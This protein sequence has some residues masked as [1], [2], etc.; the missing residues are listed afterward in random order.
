M[1]RFASLLVVMVI[2][3]ALNGQQ[4]A[5]DLIL[6]NGKIITVDERFT[7]AQAVA[8]RGD[9]FVAIGTNQ[10]IARLAGPNTRR[11]DLRGKAVIPGLIDNHMH[12][13]R[14]GATWQSEVRWDGIG[15]RK[16]ALD[17]LRARAKAV[18][19]G[20][21]IYS[22]G[23]WT[24]DQF[25][26]DSRPFTRN[27]LDDAAPN[28]PVLL[29]ASYYETYLNSRALQAL[30]IDEKSP[31]E[32]WLVRDAAGKPTGRILEAGIRGLAARLPEPAPSEIEASS[33]AMI[34]DLNRA[35][36]T[37]FG[38][39]GCEADLLPIYRRWAAQGQL[40]VRVF[41][42]TGVGAGTTP[43]QVGRALPLIAQMK[44]F[45]GDSYI[46][47]VSFG[48]SVYGPLHD[49]MFL[50]KSD[51]RPEQLAQWRR[52][53]TE[54]AKAGLPLHVHA[55][56]EDTIDAFLDQIEAINKEY[57]IRNLR[58]VLAHVNRLNA[59]Q[60]A[61]MRELGLYAAV[62]PWGVINGGINQ[63]VFGDSALDMPALSTIQN[64]GVTWGLGSDGSRANQ[65]LPFTTLWW[66]VTGK[67]VGGTKALRQTISREDALIAHT[68]KNAYLLFQENNLGSI[69]SGK[70]AD[71]LVLDRDYLT[72]PADQIKDI[73]PVMTIVGGRIVFDA[74]AGVVARASGWSVP[75]TPH[76]HPDL[77]GIWTNSTMTP[78][79]RPPELAGKEFFTREEAAEFEKRVRDRNNGDRR[80]ANPEADLT[81]GYNDFW[82]D[83]GTN[84]VSTLR[85]SI[86]V[87]PPDG[88]VPQ[89]TPEAQK[90]AAARAEARRLRPSDGPEDRS[91]A[92]RCIARGNTGPP[93][94]PA[95]YNNNYQIVQTTD[96]VMILLEMI[97]DARIIP[98]DGRPHVPR[99]VQQWLGDS[100]G[101]WEGNT[102]VVETTNFTGKTNF[103]G[104]GEAL[105]VV[106]R[107]TRV[108][109]TTL[110]YQF[111]VEDPQAFTRP[112]S[113]EIPM[114]K[115]EGPVFEYACHEGNLSMT[116]IL[117]A[118]RAEEKAA[119]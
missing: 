89:L 72:V 31:A 42:I 2:V 18:R 7:I 113:G 5:P 101:R 28:N 11:I 66:A 46:D 77:Q 65:I 41:C 86:I 82:W 81:T 51:P 116:N 52:I 13:L 102:L 60:L 100:R 38:S 88:R 15:S 4:P 96:H 71:L 36:L 9:R 49:P 85:T 111:T 67:M 24:I 95:G 80:D 106:E 50:K 63:R 108:D 25:A 8:I 119:K 58:W 26:D 55:E 84:V 69:Q 68:R 93:M 112:W 75:R 29:Q 22:L 45:Q 39:A 115:T 90:A 59:S 62:H 40:N 74:E 70:L 94:L 27:E 12:L 30:G 56:L 37:A 6:S 92:D 32:S 1:R 91:L 97:H 64:S 98:L 114:K 10:E 53:T 35:G 83:R 117:E 14:A 79:E 57:P 34:K 19:A 87:D 61:R 3:L 76:G 110:L 44:L 73:K 105:R 20:E 104:S 47:H 103:R 48:E 23:G 109:E 16:Q 107:F 118:A 99:N 54:I 21:W 17:M 33:A 78:L 43:E